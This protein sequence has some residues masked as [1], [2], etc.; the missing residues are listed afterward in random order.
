MKALKT[1][2]KISLLFVTVLVMALALALAGCGEDK[3]GNGGKS[4]AS[5]TSAETAE[6]SEGGEATVETAG[7]SEAAH[8]NNARISSMSFWMP[9]G[10][11]IENADPTFYV[12]KEEGGDNMLLVSFNEKDIYTDNDGNPPADMKA[13]L[14]VFASYNEG[15]EKT[16]VAGYDAYVKKAPESNGLVCKCIAG[17]A[18]DDG[19]YVVNLS[20]GSAYDDAGNLRSTA[21]GLSE[22]EIAT[23]DSVL[24]SFKKL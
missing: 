10:Y 21:E 6:S 8:V 20:D 13:A 4:T 15:G 14:E 18:G 11:L 5:A 16:T 2:K 17:I 1:K 3:A 23:F 24:K 22:D 7:D 12:M 19:I 9:E